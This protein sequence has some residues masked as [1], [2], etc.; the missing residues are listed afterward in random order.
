MLP[1]K[2]AFNMTKM[3]SFRIKLSASDRLGSRD[4]LIRTQARPFFGN[5]PGIRRAARGAEKARLRGTRTSTPLK[6]TSPKSSPILEAPLHR[7]DAPAL[8]GTDENAARKTP[9]RRDPRDPEPWIDEH[10]VQ[11]GGDRR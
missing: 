10:T 8:F 11:G 7:G 5:S 3:A 2:L 1:G 6:Q 4:K 9:K